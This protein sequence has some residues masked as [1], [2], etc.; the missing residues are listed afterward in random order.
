MKGKKI[1]VITGMCCLVIVATVTINATPKGNE[2]KNLKVLPK[3]IRSK[4]LN[5]IM[6]DEFSGG[7]GMTC[8]SCHTKVKGSEK[9][10]YASDEKPEKNIARNMMRMTLKMNR[11]YFGI[12]HP[13]IGS[14]G[15]TVTCVTCHKGE[16]FPGEGQ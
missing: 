7:T 10:D 11:R 6:V 13:L 16:P 4:D 9:L 5:A 12:K 8:G 3:N 2:F 14:Q 15:L 1:K